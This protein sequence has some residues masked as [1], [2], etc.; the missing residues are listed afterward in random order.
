L[1]AGRNDGAYDV[2]IVGAGIAG[3]SAAY[4]LA[5]HARVVVLEREAQPGYHSTG[6]SAALFSETYGNAAVRALSRASRAFFDA[7]PAGFAEHDLLAPRGVVFFGR[8]EQHAALE[9]QAEE[10][11]AT[12]G[13]IEWLAPDEILA[14]VPALRPEWAAAGFAEPEAEDIDV[15]ALLSGFLRS[16]RAA[17]A[18]LLTDAALEA[19]DYGRQWR[20][21]TRAGE[22]RA[23]VLVNAAGAWADEVA[24]LAGAAP[25]GLAPLRRSAIVF[26]CPRHGGATGWPIA[27][28]AT[29]DLYFRPEAGRFLASPADETPSPP[30]DAQP[31]ELDIAA[32]VARLQQV[33]TF[34][35]A[36]I[37]A[38]WA[39]L[40]T[41]APD[42]TLVA[43]YDPARA[44]FF[45]LAG[46]GGYGIQ[47]APAMGQLVAARITNKP[48]PTALVDAGVDPA[49]LDP[50]RFSQRT[51]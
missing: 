42:R 28:D 36:R 8:S 27:V 43:G 24:T 6:R 18:Q 46:Q 10:L 39:G 41:F 26:E 17:G 11:R 7:P 12:G 13:R 38:R 30:C 51:R 5:P 34:Q 25:L 1:S 3:A 19:A 16:A 37:T 47:S 32:L 31:E 15:H 20:L 4:F 44:K 29:E 45:W 35:V 50:A 49:A 48:L 23:E 21:R 9:A 33:T 2:A 40:R 14:R 22:V